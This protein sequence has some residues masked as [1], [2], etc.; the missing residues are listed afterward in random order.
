[1]GRLLERLLEMA[2]AAPKAGSDGDHQ[3]VF[4]ITRDPYSERWREA[5][6]N[7]RQHQ[8]CLSGTISWLQT[9]HPGLY[10]ELSEVLPRELDR[11]ANEQAPLPIFDRILEAWVAAHVHAF[12]LYRAAGGDAGDA[13]QTGYP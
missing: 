12:A 10:R 11:L 3:G 13:T 8:H 6:D 1:M 5:W 2:G 9:A 4:P 7:V